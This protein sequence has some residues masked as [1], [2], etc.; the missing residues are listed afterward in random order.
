MCITVLK[1]P[2]YRVTEAGYGS[3][4]LP[5]EI[6]FRNRE[7]PK[8]IKFEYDLFLRLDDAPPVHHIRCEKLTFQNPTED[9][10]KKLI[11]A[12]GVSVFILKTESEKKSVN[13]Y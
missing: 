2:P 9:F 10:R 13:Y 12:G 8:K 5:I 1:E 11:K 3:F 7:E 4:L 6:Y